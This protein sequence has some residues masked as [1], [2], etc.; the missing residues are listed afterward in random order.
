[1][2]DSTR[3]DRLWRGAAASG[4]GM[5]LAVCLGCAPEA[6]PAS[7]ASLPPNAPAARHEAGPADTTPAP[8]AAAPAL[9]RAM[10]VDTLAL[11]LASD[12]GLNWEEVAAEAGVES[13]RPIDAARSGVRAMTAQ[14]H[15]VAYPPIPQAAGAGMSLQAV[16]ASEGRASLALYGSAALVDWFVLD[17]P[18]RESDPEAFLRRILPSFARRP[19]PMPCVPA[20]IGDFDTRRQLIRLETAGRTP[21]FA[22]FEL[23]PPGKYG[24]EFTRLELRREMPTPDDLGCTAGT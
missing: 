17:K 2:R 4:L 6:A 12:R 21:L 18:R 9:P 10:A 11:E 5:G 19:Q 23:Q 22:T 1:M 14:V 20:P 3:L 7:S 15:L 16:D 13:L 8:S 24:P